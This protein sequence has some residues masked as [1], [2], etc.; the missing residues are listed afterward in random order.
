VLWNDGFLS[1]SLEATKLSAGP[2]ALFKDMGGEFHAKKKTNSSKTG[3]FRY[4]FF[5]LPPIVFVPPVL[6]REVKDIEV[7]GPSSPSSGCIIP[8]SV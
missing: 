7:A 8:H 4:V 6:P 2:A 5:N 3:L 1:D